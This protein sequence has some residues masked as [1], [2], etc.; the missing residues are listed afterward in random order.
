MPLFCHFSTSFSLLSTILQFRLSSIRV[1]LSRVSIKRTRELI[2]SDYLSAISNIIYQA[3]FTFICSYS[4]DQD[5]CEGVKCDKNAECVQFVLGGRQQCVC[6]EGWKG[7]GRN[8]YGKDGESIV[9]SIA[10]LVEQRTVEVM[11][12]ILRSL[13]RIRLEGLLLFNFSLL[14]F[15]YIV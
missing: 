10:Q 14:F 5:R 11:L 3:L 4:A 6:K 8:C 12:D 1:G 9:P 15:P 7:D 13:V 2:F